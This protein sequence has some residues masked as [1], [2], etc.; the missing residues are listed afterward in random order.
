MFF[1]GFQVMELL[2]ACVEDM[3]AP[4]G[5]RVISPR[6]LKQSLSTGRLAFTRKHW[7]PRSPA[8]AQKT[9]SVERTVYVK[10]DLI[11]PGVMMH[12]A[13]QPPLL[14]GTPVGVFSGHVALD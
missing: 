8:T 2:F 9:R 5:L 14:S 11:G 1:N 4:P 7:R 10:D 13:A 6:I 12:Q 3:G